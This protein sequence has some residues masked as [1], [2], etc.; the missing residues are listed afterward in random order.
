MWICEVEMNTWIRKRSAPFS[1]SAARSM[2]P[3]TTRASDAITGPFTLVAISRT[4]SN[5]PSEEI[6]KPASRMSTCRRASCSAI[7]TFSSFV[8]AMPG[9]CS[10]SRR[11]VS[12]NRTTSGSVLT[13]AAPCPRSAA[14]ASSAAAAGP[15]LRAGRIRASR[16]FARNS[17]NPPSA[18]AIQRF[19]N[20]PSWISPRICRIVS[21]V[22]SSITRA[23]E[24]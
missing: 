9:A 19:A 17:G 4:A 7:S 13:T 16:R 10:P 2:S 12:K 22:P 20:E 5:S 21:R 24:T 23:P 3:G 15:R 6:A 18:S 11:V 1:A 8:S 14:T